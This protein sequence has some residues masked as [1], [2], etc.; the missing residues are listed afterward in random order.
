MPSHVI[1]DEIRIKYPTIAAHYH[2][3]TSWGRSN[4]CL[5]SK[6]GSPVEDLY[7]IIRRNRRS[8]RCTYYNRDM[9]VFEYFECQSY[10]DVCGWVFHLFTKYFKPWIDPGKENLL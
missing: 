2:M 1:E 4:V 8:Y 7:L 5:Q 3:T 6:P 9:I 10:K